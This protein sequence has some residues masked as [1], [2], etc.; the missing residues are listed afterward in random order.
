MKLPR[1][2]DGTGLAKDLRKLGYEI[3]RQKGSH[4]RV[5]TQAGGEHHEV[6]PAHRPIKPGTLASILKRK[7]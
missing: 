7:D 1:D 6:I 2:V 5:T 3:T 4:I